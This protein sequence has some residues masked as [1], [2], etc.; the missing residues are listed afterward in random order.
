MRSALNLA[1]IVIIAAA[2][3]FG[4]LFISGSMTG[5]LALEYWYRITAITG[6][7]LIASLMLLSITTKRK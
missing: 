1:L 4:A 3:M 5:A 6:I 7:A 2:V